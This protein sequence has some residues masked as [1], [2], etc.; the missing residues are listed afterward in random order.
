[1][2]TFKIKDK[3]IMIKVKG[4]LMTNYPV[5][6]SSNDGRRPNSFYDRNL[7]PAWQKD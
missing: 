7:F 1:M 2:T 4:G 5:I 3:G 6:Q